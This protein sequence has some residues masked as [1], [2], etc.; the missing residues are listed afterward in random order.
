MPEVNTA[1]TEV[2]TR[3]GR[4]P[5]VLASGQSLAEAKAAAADKVREARANLKSAQEDA[6]VATAAWN[7]AGKAAKNA[8]D[9]EAA[10]KTALEVAKKKL[11]EAKEAAKT[12]TATSKAAFI[13]VTAKNKVVE[14]AT[15]AVSDALAA[16]QALVTPR[17]AAAST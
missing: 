1:V 12:A 17:G 3:G 11:P 6:K 15:K 4:K 13:D 2:K 14:K 9:A 7:T 10:A 5:T 16:Q 8:L